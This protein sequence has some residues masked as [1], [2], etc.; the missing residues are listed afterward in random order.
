MV[1]LEISPLLV[2][3]YGCLKIAVS[4]QRSAISP[5]LLRRPASHVGQAACPVAGHRGEAT[6]RPILPFFV[7]CGAASGGEDHGRLRVVQAT[8]VT[9]NPYVSLL[10]QAMQAQAPGLDWWVTADLSPEWAAA[11]GERI[12]VLHL[13]WPNLFYQAEGRWGRARSLLSLLKVLSGLQVKGVALVHTVHNL[14]PHESPTVA[15]DWLATLWLLRYA[16]VIHV[17]D[18]ETA[19]EVGRVRW[20]RRRERVWV[21]PHG[22]YLDAYPNT[23][24]RTETRRRLDV[25][26]DAFVYLFLG[27]IRPYKGVDDLLD[28][29]RRVGREQDCL[30]V[31]GNAR[32]RDGA[33]VERLLRRGAA[34]PRLR[35]QV[36]YVPDDEVQDYMNAADICVLPYRRAVT[37][38]SALLAFSFGRPI[39][40]PRLGPFPRL[41]GADERGILYDP[42]SEGGLAAAL[43]RAR[44]LDLATMGTAALAYARALD[45]NDLARQHLAAYQEAMA[46]ARRRR[47]QGLASPW[48]AVEDSHR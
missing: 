15:L 11:H 27:Q 47:R 19:R 6:Y 23:R 35:I 46:R 37:S 39:V 26:E 31:A 22:H 24:S 9:Q 44:E 20:G 48:P 43:G 14:V 29:F 38:G 40:A 45:W 18:P 7:D 16:D 2:A 28:A 3:R 32:P 12:D 1:A 17:H 41:V 30:I 13:H 36:G 21:I 42:Q 10:G 4:D 33:Y 8:R 25:P 5:P 34:D